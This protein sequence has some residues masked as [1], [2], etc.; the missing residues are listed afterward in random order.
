MQVINGV[1]FNYFY[2]NC[3]S[4]FIIEI[5]WNFDWLLDNIWNEIKTLDAINLLFHSESISKLLLKMRAIYLSP[6][7][8]Q[9]NLR[10]VFGKSIRSNYLFTLNWRNGKCLDVG[11]P[12]RTWQRR[13]EPSTITLLGKKFLP[14]FHSCV[15]HE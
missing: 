10:P 11:R 4:S 14:K 2:T 7:I 13:D 12:S 1:L 3:S 15:S 9:P 6:K 8:I 5:C